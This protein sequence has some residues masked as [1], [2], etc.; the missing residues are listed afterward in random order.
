MGDT[1]ADA[2]RVVKA[3]GRLDASTGVLF[4]QECRAVID[5]GESDL[6]IDLSGLDYISSAGLR[7]LLVLAKQ[8]KTAG[9]R[10]AL[11]GAKKPVQ[12]VFDVTGYTTLLDVFPNHDA[13][14]AHLSMR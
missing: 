11:Y 3:R 9:G 2:F 10:L 14:A 1:M 13:A 7:V 12:E 5:G 6:G 4:E 8:L